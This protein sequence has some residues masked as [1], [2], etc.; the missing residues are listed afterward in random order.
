MATR[1]S[2]AH[3]NALSDAFGTA[4]ASGSIEIRTGAAPAAT[5]DADTGTLLWSFTFDATP[6]DAAA[7][8]VADNQEDWTGASVATGTAAH[9]RIKSS[10]GTVF[11]QGTVGSGSGDIDL[12]SVSIVAPGVITIGAG[13]F[14]HTVPQV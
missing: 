6:F 4:V 7:A 8:G 10:G 9:Y 12:S 3:A 1:I 11:S 13:N 5:T 14:T 2:E